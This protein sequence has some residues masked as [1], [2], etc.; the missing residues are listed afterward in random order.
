V[1]EEQPLAEPAP[2]VAAARDALHTVTAWGAALPLPLR[3]AAAAAAAEL[4][5]RADP[6]YPPAA[7]PATDPEL[8][9]ATAAYLLADARAH[10]IAA[11]ELADPTDRTDPIGL[12]LAARE[13]TDPL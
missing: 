5:L 8:T 9:P 4:E 10:L 6:P 1:D 3:L 7:V 11:I 12:A 13:L 2:L